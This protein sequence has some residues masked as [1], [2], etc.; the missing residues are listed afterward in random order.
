MKSYSRNLL[1]FVIPVIFMLCISCSSAPEIYQSDYFGELTLNESN[2]LDYIYS[3]P[4]ISLRNS[5]IQVMDFEMLAPEPEDEDDEDDQDDVRWADAGKRFKEIIIEKT[6]P[7][8]SSKYG[9]TLIDN[10]ADYILE[11]RILEF[12]RGSRAARYFVGFG[13]GAGYLVFDMKIID[14]KSGKTVIAAH[15]KR[16]A[17]RAWDDIVDLMN[18]VADDELPE[19]FENVIK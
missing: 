6:T 5:S 10:P 13:A 14:K 3:D 16:F 11:G 15:H 7:K 8:I 2:D 18:D 4:Q 12:E 19:L 1:F 9:I 17:A